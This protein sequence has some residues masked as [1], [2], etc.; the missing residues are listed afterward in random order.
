MKI[1]FFVLIGLIIGVGFVSAT[2]I[3]ARYP[4]SEASKSF[5][6]SSPN[7]ILRLD[8][9]FN[10]VCKYNV[11]SAKNYSQMEEY[12]SETGGKIHKQNFI[13]LAEGYHRYFVRCRN[14]DS[15]NSSEELAELV[16]NVN[17][18]VSADLEL[19]EEEPLK[20]GKID[21]ELK[22]S[23]I[24]SGAP[25]LEYSL[26]GEKFKPIPLTGSLQ[27]WE[28]HLVLEDDIGEGVLSFRF[29][30]TDL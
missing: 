20:A 15:D 29:R 30:A 2:S 6:V 28:G 7:V 22:T 12:F 23:K 26:D 4:F 27:D 1:G 25:V 8:T 5:E 14:Y 24:V 19:S 3:E 16:I 18:L 9:A 11:G 17:S 10:G 13:G 21:I